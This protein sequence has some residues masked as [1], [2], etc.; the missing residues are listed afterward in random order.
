MIAIL[1]TLFTS[2]SFAQQ[3][4]YDCSH[5]EPFTPLEILKADVI[6]YRLGKIQDDEEVCKT[7]SP[8]LIPVKDIR[9]READWY[10]CNQHQPTEFLACDVTYKNQPAKIQIKPAMV[11]RHWKPSDALDVHLHT[12]LIPHNDW[13]QHHDNFTRV[14]YSD[15]N[16]RELTLNGSYGGRGPSADQE[17]YFVSVRFYR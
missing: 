10:Y 3:Q 13:D 1:F 17:N 16:L 6:V 8:L 7:T 4:P 12:Y 9:G 5:F 15:L 14:L 11:I 2:V